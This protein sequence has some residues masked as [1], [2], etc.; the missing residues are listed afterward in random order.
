MK[1]KFRIKTVE[2]N[3]VK[4]YY[5]QVRKWFLYED[6]S[7]L[8]KKIGYICACSIKQLAVDT[9]NDYKNIQKPKITYDYNCDKPNEK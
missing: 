8:D 6:I 2:E 5:P 9:I 4:N 1:Q 3:G 7:H